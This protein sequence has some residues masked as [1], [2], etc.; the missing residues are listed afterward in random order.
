[1]TKTEFLH[2]LQENL[3]AL[4]E[5][6]RDERILFF[7][8]LIDDKIEAGLGEEDAV[9]EIGDPTDIAKQI[10]AEFNTPSTEPEQKAPK[11]RRKLK[12]WEI[13]L[14]CIGSPIWGSIAI[15]VAAVIFSLYASLWAV[16]ISLWAADLAFA[17]GSVAGVVAFFPLIFS[18][19][20]DFAL[21]MLGSGLVNGALAIFM[22]Y[23]CKYL[24]LLSIKLIKLFF[25]R[26]GR[27]SK[28]E[29]KKP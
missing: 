4:S 26:I 10:T 15:A 25:G 2:Q 29:A 24:T 22:F 18:K 14:I 27:T 21:L 1:M 7:G 8:E 16:V 20:F 23:P 3:D 17:L 6:D 11:V 13:A 12:G 9:R 5:A 28:K 19:N